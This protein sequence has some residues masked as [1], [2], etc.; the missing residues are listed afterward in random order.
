[1]RAFLGALM[2]EGVISI[3]VLV[4]LCL[5]VWFGGQFLADEQNDLVKERILIIAVLIGIFLVL[6]VVQKMLAVRNAMRIEQQLKNQSGSQLSGADADKKAEIEALSKK[7]DESL[8]ALKKTKGGKSALFTLPW[9]IIIGPPGS[10]KTTALQESGLNFPA[11]QGGA[12]VRGIGG[13]RNCDWWFTEDGILLDTAGRYTTVAEDQEEWFAF[14]DMIR[15]SR[16][17]KPING[18]IVA[19]AIDDLFRATQNE[20]DQIAKDVRN[21]LDELA[22]RLQGVFPVYL[23]F[24]KCDLVQGFVEFYEDF[25]K[26]QRGQVWGFTMP[27]SLPEKQYTEIFSDEIGRMSRN[28]NARQLELLATERP[29]GKKQNIYLFPRQFQLASD[30]MKELIGALFA[31]NA[32]QESA[33]L[34]GVYFTSGTQKGTPIDQLL[35]RMGETMGFGSVPQGSEDRVEKKSFFIH[36]LFTK[37][38]FHDKTLAR[39]NSRVLRKRRTV[40]VTL[41]VLSLMALAFMSYALIGSFVGNNSMINKV[42]A[43]GVAVRETDTDNRVQ[44]EALE[45]LEGL[46]RELARLD[47]Y[48]RDGRPVSLSFGMYQGNSMFEAGAKLYFERLNPMHVQPCHDRVERE[49]GELVATLEP[50][51]PSEDYQRLLDLWRVYRMMSGK[52]PAQPSLVATILKKEQRW[53][54]PLIGAQVDEIEALAGEQLEFYAS[55]L[56][57]AT[58]EAD[59]FGLLLKVDEQLDDRASNKLENALWTVSAYEAII[60]HTSEKRKALGLDVL[61]PNNTAY[62]EVRM[63]GVSGTNIT[64][65]NAYTQEAWDTDVK[66]LI[67]ERARDLS[68]LYKELNLTRGEDEIRK[69][70]YERHRKSHIAAWDLFLTQVY[71]KDS[72]FS[73]VAKTNEALETLRQPGEQSPYRQ[74]VRNVWAKR[75]LQLSVDNRVDGPSEEET[76]AL[77]SAMN[78]LEDFYK[79]YNTFAT[80]TKAGARVMP[81]LSNTEP[82]TNLATAFITAAQD[83]PKPFPQRDEAVKTAFKRIVD[84]GFNALRIEA[85]AEATKRWETGPRDLWQTNLEDKFPMRY[86]AAS[87]ATMVN[88]AR[89]FNPVDGQLWNVERRL[90]AV[91]ELPFHGGNTL[92]TLSSDYENTIRLA[93]DITDAMFDKPDSQLVKVRFSVTL[94][95]KGLLVSSRIEIASDKDGN[96]Q[97]LTYNDNPANTKDFVWEQFNTGTSKLGARLSAWYSEARLALIPVDHMDKDWGLLRLLWKDSVKFEPDVEDGRQVYRTAWHFRSPDSQIFELKAKV[98]PAKKNNPFERE[99]FGRF[100]LA[101]KVIK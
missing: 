64:R 18:A 75:Q 81:H 7:F 43:A 60:Q 55:Q 37:V 35:A 22:A 70:L 6:F 38:I 97:K 95:Q 34:R 11:V 15:T 79:A 65:L 100:T 50:N 90:R 30:K 76:K 74:L 29:P 89:L 25:T 1:M 98:T 91:A 49:L 13:T 36:Q 20:L 9:Y 40:R 82:L 26:E 53:T 8:E 28:V 2:K 23:M 62:L 66:S 17:D 88:F 44:L 73:D 57:E 96:I 5:L 48:R 31:A 47:E 19:V 68:D 58:V 92:L 21:R 85:E 14:L 27:Y 59:R 69:D 54:G 46:R 84:A 78:A 72:V 87:T 32:F 63:D 33:M 94:D 77:E 52:L 101:D 93:T 12:K 16:K 4:L 3:V 71:P 42:E 61:V 45:K 99:L 67:D 86:D 56:A 24:T 51:S 83:L 80:V 39:S 41:S 10:G